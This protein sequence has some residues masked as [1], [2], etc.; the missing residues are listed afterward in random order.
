MKKTFIISLSLYFFSTSLYADYGITGLLSIRK[1]N[2][3]LSECIDASIK[4]A[5][6][7]GMN[8]IEKTSLA[9]N[10]SEISG[11]NSKGFSLQTN[12]LGYNNKSGAYL[13]YYVING[14]HKKKQE[15][16]ATKYGDE[17]YNIIRKQYGAITGGR[18]RY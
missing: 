16:F 11:I 3:G 13:I 2:I 4:A 5:K 15:E 10:T 1:P 8:G 17:F 12:C 6:I 18:T 14:S 7:I 9:P